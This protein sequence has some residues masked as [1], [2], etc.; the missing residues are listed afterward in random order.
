[1]RTRIPIV[2]AAFAV[3]MLVGACTKTTQQSEETIMVLTERN[4]N[5]AIDSLIAMHGEEHRTRIEQGVRQAASM[6][7]S[8]DGSAEDF[9]AV[10]AEHFITDQELLDKTFQRFEHNLMLIN[11]YLTEL[12][13]DLMVPLHLD[14]GPIIGVDHLFGRFAPEAHVNTDMFKTKLAFAAL[15]NFPLS[16]LEQRLEQGAEWS[17]REWAERRLAQRF[18][19]R[20]PAEANQ[21]VTTAYTIADTYI[22]GY[23]IHMHHVL[24]DEGERLFPEGL[25]LISHWGLRDELKAQYAKDDGLPRQE[26]IHRIMQRIVTQEIPE[27]VIDNPAVDWYIAEN[28]VVPA[29]ESPAGAE[30]AQREPDTRY[31]MWLKVFNAERA[32]DPYHPENSTHIARRFNEDREIP[33]E[34]VEQLFVDVLSSPLLTDVA[35]LIRERLGRDLQPFDIWY[36][37]FKTKPPLTEDELDRIVREKYPTVEAFEKDI[38]DILVRLGFTFDRAQYLADHISVDAARGAGHAMGAGR[39]SDNAHLRTRV[40]ESGMNYKG[41]NIAIHELGHNVEQVMSYQMMDHTLLRGVPNTAFTEGFAFVFQSR[42]LD[43]LGLDVENPDA[44]ALNTLDVLWSTYEI[45]GVALVDMR[46]W[47]WLYENPDAT[48]EQLREADLRIAKEVWNDYYAPVLGMED[49]PLLAIYSHTIDGG[50]YTPDYPLGHIIAFQIE[51]YLKERSLATEMERMCAI[52]NV[53]PDLWMQKA[54]GGPISTAPL[55]DAARKALDS[56]K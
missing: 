55:L 22:S 29:G 27:E 52:G 7:R 39:L 56:L 30:P 23:N 26:L 1:M 33:E 44:E 25:K 38:P 51:Q 5:G 35:A 37:G 49:Q 46:V 42:D 48:P 20:V 9:I 17:R 53:T 18:D 6:W 3:I 11:G 12:R 32:V 24:N 14:T 34:D 50:M 21:Q 16:T 36:P 10:C 47:R 41:Y 28:V 8:D 2:F 13:R 40:P 4:I 15:L 54:V 19:T 45:A 43:L 31:E